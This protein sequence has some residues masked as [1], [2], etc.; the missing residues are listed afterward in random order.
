MAIQHNQNKGPR[1]FLI[2]L[3]LCM[4]TLGAILG[5]QKAQASS[6]WIPLSALVSEQKLTDII[7]E[8]TAPSADIES[9][10]ELAIGYEQGDLLVVDF[11]SS[12]LCGVGGCAIAAYQVSTGDRI[13]FTYAIRPGRTGNIVEVIEI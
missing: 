11:K 8:N 12:T 7:S 1:L 10:S 5:L 2:A 9:L 6:E 3:A 4:L 13:L